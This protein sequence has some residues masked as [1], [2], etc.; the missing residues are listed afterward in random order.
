M[1]ASQLARELQREIDKHGDQE[2]V[3]YTLQPEAQFDV[4]EVSFNFDGDEP[5]IVIDGEPIHR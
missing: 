3:L 2:V 4:S 1:L 5:A